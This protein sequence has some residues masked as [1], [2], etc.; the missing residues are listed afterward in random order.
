MGHL[1]DPPGSPPYVSR[2]MSAASLL[3]FTLVRVPRGQPR[4]SQEA[5]RAA[6]AAD[7][8]RLHQPAPN[9]TTEIEISGPFHVIVDGTELDEYGVWER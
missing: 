2:V 9:G 3:T 4:P 7:R 6:L 8:E 5:L 1:L